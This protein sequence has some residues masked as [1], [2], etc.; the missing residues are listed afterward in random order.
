MSRSSSPFGRQRKIASPETPTAQTLA[1]ARTLEARDR[2]PGEPALSE[3]SALGLDVPD[4]DAL[5]RYR[6]QRIREQLRRFDYAGIV[7]CDPIN[8]R[9]AT[10]STNMQVWCMHNAVR[11]AYVATDGPVVL[12]DFHGCGHLSEHLGLVDE[13]R[14]ASAYY[15]MGAGPRYQELAAK[16]AAELADLVA[17]SGGGNRRIGLDRGNQEGVAAL[18]QLGIETYNGEELMEQARAIKSADEIKA[19]RC[20]LAACE[21][22]MQIMRQNLV[23]GVT[24]N[25]LWSFL[26]AEN[27]ARGGEWIETRLLAS[28]ARTNPWFHECSSR[29]IEDGDIVAFDTDLIGPYGYC[30]D[31][32]RTWLC[33][34]GRPSTEQ[35]VLYTMALEQIQ[36]NISILKAG[37]SFAELTERAM[38]LPPEYIA[39]RYSVLYHGVGLCDE[40]PSIAY[41][42]D[43]AL[44][45]YDGVLEENMCLCVESY[46][47]RVGGHEGVK[48]EEQVRI[49]RD[50][51]EVLSSYPIE[52][53]FGR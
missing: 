30:S 32:S 27:I 51:C 26:H 6:L 17:S 42:E 21:S 8:S 16:W 31:I 45:G 29:V 18:N 7:L 34:E 2:G 14:P 3:W 50:G 38:S 1:Y 12:F 24:E 33:G 52:G 4:L 48:L 20:S 36:A 49:T 23:P 40:H 11:Y 47:G 25:R 19:M 5:R 37:I 41:K 22:A 9:Y 46:I 53:L 15:Y 28:G 43:Y 44:T 13:I 10:D 35:S 39:N